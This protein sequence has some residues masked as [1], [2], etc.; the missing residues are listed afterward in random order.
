MCYIIS[1]LESTVEKVIL[2]LNVFYVNIIQA[3]HC[4]I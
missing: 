1:Y 2:E 3:L 4:H